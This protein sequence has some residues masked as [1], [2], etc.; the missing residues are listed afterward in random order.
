MSPENGVPCDGGCE[1]SGSVPPGPYAY[2]FGQYLG[3]GYVARHPRG[4]YRLR[5][6]CCDTYPAIMDEV[7]A[8][9]RTVMPASKVGRTQRIGCTEVASYSKHWPC[10]LPQTGPGVKHT[11]PIVLEAWQQEIVDQETRAFVRGL[12]HSDGSRCMNRVQGGAYEYPRYFFSN[13]SE[14]IL[15]LFCDAL[16]RLGIEWRRNGPWSVSVARREAVAAL[17]EF[18]GPKR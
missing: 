1:L 9:L 12:I 8:A 15:W 3:D 4:V 16:D 18:V 2:L 13:R 17:D 7:E 10:L 14:D 11:R 6:V 5:I